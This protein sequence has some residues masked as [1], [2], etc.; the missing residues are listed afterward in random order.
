MRKYTLLIGIIFFSV[1]AFAQ[2]RVGKIK[3][4]KTA[5]L[6]RK[7]D[8]AIQLIDVRK[9]DEFENGHLK[10]AININVL[11]DDFIY[12]IQN[13]DKSKKVYVYCQ[14]GKRSAKAAKILSENGFRKIMDLEGGYLNWQKYQ[15]NLKPFN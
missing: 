6:E 9:P 2:Q 11:S 10:G 15:E 7:L 3:L 4:I 5:K 8:K 14:S 13:L 1:S 12:K